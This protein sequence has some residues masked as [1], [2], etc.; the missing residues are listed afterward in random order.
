MKKRSLKP[1]WILLIVMASLTLVAILIG[2]LNALVGKGQWRIGW[3]NY[4]YDEEGYQIGGC[5]VYET[6]ITELEL[7][8]LS[9]EVEVLF[10]EDDAYPS[11][12]ETSVNPLSESAQLRWK[13]ENGKLTVKCR[14]SGTYL[15]SGAPDKSLTVRIPS[16]GAAGLKNVVVKSVSASV[17]LRGIHSERL[18][19]NTVSGRIGL[20]GCAAPIVALDTVRGS[21]SAKG[22]FENCFVLSSVSGNFQLTPVSCPKNLEIR[23]VKGDSRLTLPADSSFRIAFRSVSGKLISDFAL[24]DRGGE[25]VCGDGDCSIQTETTSGGLTIEKAGA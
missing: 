9:G 25:S 11:L 1:L 6:E 5:T 2:V 21:V 14:K 12:I 19:I 10:T 3:Q 23:S 7:D 24:T 22:E 16:K 15:S 17:T 20:D 18:E 13:A 4:R 8:W